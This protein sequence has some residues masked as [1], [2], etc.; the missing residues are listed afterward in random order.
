MMFTKTVEKYLGHLKEKE[1]YNAYSISDDY[2]LI[3]GKG[4]ID[5]NNSWNYHNNYDDSENTLWF[6]WTNKHKTLLKQEKW[7]TLSESE[8][9][10]ELNKRVEDQIKIWET[11]ID[12]LKTKLIK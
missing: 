2:E 11:Q 8:A 10:E 3:F 9:K 4:Y 1:K 7:W 12:K 5:S 6:E